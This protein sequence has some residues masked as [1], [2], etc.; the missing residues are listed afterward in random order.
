MKVLCCAVTA[1]IAAA[2]AKASKNEAPA[3]GE[4]VHPAMATA[5]ESDAD[6]G[7][8]IGD[9]TID[10][11]NNLRGRGAVLSSNDEDAAIVSVGSTVRLSKMD[12]HNENL[13]DYYG[14]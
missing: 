10:T 3:H 9:V 8:G 7:S 14:F 6:D 5:I 1:L 2:S 11:V 4:D 12:A 13:N